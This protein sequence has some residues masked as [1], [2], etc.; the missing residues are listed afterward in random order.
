MLTP[1]QK[2]ILQELVNIAFGSAT[3]SMAELM[4]AFATLSVPSIHFLPIEQFNEHLRTVVCDDQP[5]YLSQQVFTGSMKGETIFILEQTSVDNLVR[6]LYTD[7]EQI[8]QAHINDAVLEVNNI[9]SVTTIG[10]LAEIMKMQTNF[11]V[12][13]LRIF[14]DREF[15]DLSELAEYD[16][17]IIIETLMRFEQEQIC[18]HLLILTASAM[19]QEL[20]HA[21]DQIA[22]E[23]M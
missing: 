14:A 19:M 10:K 4:D 2:E 11:M 22:G 3:A 18:G 16:A 9:L 21:L 8:T 17:V 5:L 15:A 7:E 20:Q 12:P 6:H 23:M 13:T 1:L